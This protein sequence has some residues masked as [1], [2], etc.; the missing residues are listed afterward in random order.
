MLAT[1]AL[2]T[3]VGAASMS[4]ALEDI[5][6]P[7]PCSEAVCSVPCRAVVGVTVISLLEVFEDKGAAKL[8]LPND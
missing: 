7:C 4:T 2:L 5:T 8:E 3:P 6:I 1:G